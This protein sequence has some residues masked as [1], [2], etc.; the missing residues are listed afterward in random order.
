MGF[1]IENNLQSPPDS[2]IVLSKTKSDN[3]TEKQKEEVIRPTQ[4]INLT[5][6]Q[7]KMIEDYNN[8]QEFKKKSFESL[9]EFEKF[10][11]SMKKTTERKSS[12]KLDNNQN[13]TK[14]FINNSDS[15]YESKTPINI[16]SI[17]KRKDDIKIFDKVQI[18]SKLDN[19]EL[20]AQYIKSQENPSYSKTEKYYRNRS[21]LV[22]ALIYFVFNFK[23][24]P[25]CLGDEE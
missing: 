7:I 6:E 16:D 10:L 1:D 24:K 18:K 9:N 2:D 4:I 13:R 12:P 15:Y 23:I 8:R 17:M 25:Q 11:N 5:Q 19:S 14:S 3:N 20:R 21:I 22:R